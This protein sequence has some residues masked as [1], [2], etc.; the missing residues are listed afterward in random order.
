[1]CGVRAAFINWQSENMA[2]GAC[3]TLCVLLCVATYADHA[4][5]ARMGGTADKPDMDAPLKPA[6]AAPEDGTA[7]QGPQHLASIA[8]GMRMDVVR[9]A[10]DVASAGQALR[11]RPRASRMS[12]RVWGVGVMRTPH[13]VGSDL[14]LAHPCS[15]VLSWCKPCRR[16]L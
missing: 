15:K 2:R 9:I 1:M 3:V 13:R 14:L 8:S 4:A 6:P 7:Q 11:K 12:C 16:V 10:D 5:A